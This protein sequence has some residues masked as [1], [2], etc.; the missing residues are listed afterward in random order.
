MFYATTDLG[1]LGAELKL[2]DKTLASAVRRNVRTATNQ[3]GAEVVNL[4]RSNASWSS[5]IPSATRLTVSFATRSWGVSMTTSKTRAP[6]AR[7][8]EMGS[9]GNRAVDRHPV[10][11]RDVWVDQPTRPYFFPAVEALTPKMMRRIEAAIDAAIREAGFK[12]V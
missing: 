9:R 10:F 6:N 3:A 11:G 7:P 2:V 1:R 5:R 12:G 4:A 8:L